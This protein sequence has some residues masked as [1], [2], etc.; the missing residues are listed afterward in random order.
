MG[1]LGARP[2]HFRRLVFNDGF[3]PSV[4]LH[5]RQLLHTEYSLKMCCT[6]RHLY[7]TTYLCKQQEQIVDGPHR[8]QQLR[9]VDGN[10]QYNYNAEI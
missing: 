6:L 2:D 10:T 8:K 5:R 9:A 1:A 4:P 3:C 7:L